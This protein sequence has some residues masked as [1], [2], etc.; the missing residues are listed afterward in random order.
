M[1]FLSFIT[2]NDPVAGLE[3]RE[4]TIR[5]ALLHTD[6]RT[7]A[8]RII[9]T[10][11]KALPEGTIVDGI[12]ENKA[13][14]ASALGEAAHAL[15]HPVRKFIVSIPADPVYYKIF[16]FPRGITG[17]KFNEAMELAANFQLP[18]PSAEIYADWEALPR[19]EEDGSGDSAKQ[20]A[21]LAAI[22]R[23]VAD[24][25]LE[26]MARAKL[27]T[28]ALE[29]HPL[30]IARAV[31]LTPETTLIIT[32]DPSAHTAIVTTGGML[33]FMEVLPKK[34]VPDKTLPDEVIKIQHAYASTST[35]IIYTSPLE[36][37]P[38][39]AAAAADTPLPSAAWAAAIGAGMRGI[40]PRSKDRG[41]SLTSISVAAAYQ[42]RLALTVSGFITRLTI[43]IS[44][45]FVGGF[46]AAFLLMVSIQQNFAMELNTAPA[47]AATPLDPS[48]RARAKEL[49]TIIDTMAPL[50]RQFPKWSSL[51]GDIT[52]HLPSYVSITSISIPS[53][54][55]TI[56]ISGIAPDRTS[57]NDLRNSLQNWR[58]ITNLS[59]P[60]PD[61]SQTQNIPF[62]FSF[63]M[64]D[65]QS[66]YLQ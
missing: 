64:A 66:Y 19:P 36:E 55:G 15:K 62:Q 50:V 16:E 21:A 54:K 5:I 58:D 8:P 11:E 33:R 25:Y 12:V 6:R 35:P 63:S 10:A 65:P 61:L 53:P 13:A 44:L 37:L 27:E 31:V 28:V 42:Y 24:P 40:I 26:C 38:L 32:N 4:R 3:I 45:F 56:T 7:R 43:G 1:N 47:P 49:N 29:C 59:F 60:T 2:G 23:S 51:V 20:E 18:L 52:G 34:F 14:L 39:R 48:L 17:G 9:E 30:S 41:I 46:I 57:V 22:L